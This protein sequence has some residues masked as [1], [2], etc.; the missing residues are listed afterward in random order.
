MS[1][2]MGTSVNN[3]TQHIVKFKVA[4]GLGERQTEFYAENDEAIIHEVGC[5]HT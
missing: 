5:L 1:D 2:V 3:I 4:Q